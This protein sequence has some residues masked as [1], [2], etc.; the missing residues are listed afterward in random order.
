VRRPRGSKM[1][2][3][4]VTY[5]VIMSLWNATFMESRG[6]RDSFRHSGVARNRENTFLI[7][8]A[9]YPLFRR[10]QFIFK[11]QQWFCHA[12]QGGLIEI[13]AKHC[14]YF[15]GIIAIFLHLKIHGNIYKRKN[16]WIFFFAA[17]WTWTSEDGPNGVRGWFGF[18]ELNPKGFVIVAKM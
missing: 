5:L 6:I 15:W 11:F 7:T 10:R 1:S 13:P 4:M 3:S 12:Y 8:T 14:F 9:I 16:G 2:P 18:A 17:K